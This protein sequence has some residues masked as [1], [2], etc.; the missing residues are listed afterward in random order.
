MTLSVHNTS[1]WP[2][3]D[4]ARHGTAITAHLRKYAD[5]F[6][7]DATVDSLFRDITEGR[8]VLWLIMD[9][10]EVEAVVITEIVLSDIGVRSGR[11]CVMSGERGIEAMPLIPAIEAWAREKGAVKMQQFMRPGLGRKLR[12]HGYKSTLMLVEKDL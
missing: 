7:T 3:E 4:V 8:R 6:P 5:T 1:S 2:F 11:I 12:E 9:G 10:D